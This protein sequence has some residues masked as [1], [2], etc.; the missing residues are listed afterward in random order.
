M[1]EHQIITRGDGYIELSTGIIAV[2]LI[3]K[4]VEEKKATEIEEKGSSTLYFWI[5]RERNEGR[6]KS[7]RRARQEVKWDQ[8]RTRS[9]VQ[10]REQRRRK[11]GA[12]PIMKAGWMGVHR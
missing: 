1:R 11:E 9:L 8:G 6:R 12:R 7:Q 2:M 4:Q 5:E 10:Q 3:D